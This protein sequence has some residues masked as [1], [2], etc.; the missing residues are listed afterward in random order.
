MTDKHAGDRYEIEQLLYRYAWMADK[1]KWELMDSVFAPEATVDY[2]ST[3]GKKGPYRPTLEWLHRALEG[4]PVNLH[5]TS[6]ICIEIDGDRA[7]CRCMFLAPMARQRADG[8]QEVITNAGYYFDKLTRGPSGWRI[9]E[10]VCTQTVQM[11]QL[12]S[13]YAIPE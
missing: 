8:S 9:A 13:G 10:R 1:R 3:G 4:W 12:P 2:T 6:N 7:N 5:F 11:G